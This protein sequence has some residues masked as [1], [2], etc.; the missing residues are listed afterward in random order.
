MINVEVM[1]M[2]IPGWVIAAVGKACAL[3]CRMGDLG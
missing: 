3:A 1:F 2:A